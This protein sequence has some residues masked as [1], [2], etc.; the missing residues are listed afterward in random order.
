M[1]PILHSDNFRECLQTDFEL[2]S[3]SGG[4]IALKLAD[5]QEAINTAKVESFSLLF[6]GPMTPLLPQATYRLHHQ[7]LGP[8]DIFLVPLGPEDGEMQ[9]EAVFNRLRNRQ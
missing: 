6:R 1:E 9:Y 7:K 4:S 3:E 2:P 8:I 5:V